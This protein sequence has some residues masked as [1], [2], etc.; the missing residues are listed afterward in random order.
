MAKKI[1]TPIQCRS[2]EDVCSIPRDN[3]SLPKDFWMITDGYEVT[4]AQQKMGESPSQKISVPKSIFD[5]C[6]KWYVTGKK[7]GKIPL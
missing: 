3:I 6:V 5:A 2:L 7:S 4:I 1:K